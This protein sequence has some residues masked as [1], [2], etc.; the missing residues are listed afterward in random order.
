MGCI[1]KAEKR[2]LRIVKGSIMIM[3]D[4]KK[5]SL[6]VLNG[7][8]TIEEASIIDSDE[9]KSKLWHLRLG[10]MSQRWLKKLQSKECLELTS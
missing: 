2:V 4:S 3:K 7:Q 8:T 1:I 6:Y 9:D 10:H 5:N